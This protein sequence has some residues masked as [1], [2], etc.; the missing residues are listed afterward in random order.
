VSFPDIR[1]RWLAQAQLERF[2][3]IEAA[4]QAKRTQLEAE[5]TKALAELELAALGF[6]VAALRPQVELSAPD[7]TVIRFAE[8]GKYEARDASGRWARLGPARLRE[9]TS[10]RV[11]A[12]QKLSDLAV[13]LGQLGQDLARLPEELGAF[14]GEYRRRLEA[15]S[16][17]VS[18]LDADAAQQE[19]DGFFAE[20]QEELPHSVEQELQRA[21]H[22][23]LLRGLFRPKAP[24]GLKASNDRSDGVLL[25]WE[26][27]AGAAGRLPAGFVYRLPTE[28]EWE[29]ACRAGTTTRFYYGDDPG[30]ERLGDYAWYKSNSGG[31]SHAVVLRQPN[32]WGLY[33]MYGN[34]WEW[35]L[36]WYR[37]HPGGSVTDPEG[38]TSGSVRMMRG[39]SW[40][41]DGRICRSAYRSWGA[42]SMRRENRGLRAVLAA[43]QP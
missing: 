37:T 21:K 28:A 29:Y 5:F 6:R 30:Y 39:G 15:L 17:A 22:Q 4:L 11:H 43:G 16:R 33:D 7:G 32:P 34:V 3:D 18:P 42:P 10:G 23:A 8:V 20:H 35:C 31:T 40:C 9:L 41:D 25:L 36:D 12:L 1:R 38:A 24:A 19:L 2:E 27:V 26:A 14:A 13:Q